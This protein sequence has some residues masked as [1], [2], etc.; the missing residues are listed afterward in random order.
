MEVD[1]PL[2]QST[3]IETALTELVTECP[4]LAQLEALLSQFNVFRV[5][6]ATHSELRHS[7]MLAWLFDPSGSHGL[8]DLF[9]RRWLMEVMKRGAE[10]D[11]RPKGWVSP[12]AIDVME[13]DR[14]ETHREFDFIDL[15]LEI[16]PKQGKP[17]LICIENKVGATEGPDQLKRYY[18]KIERR[19]ESFDRRIYV[20]LTAHEGTAK[21]NQF[22]DAGYKTVI[23]VLA[24]C[25]KQQED[26][27]GPEPLILM[28]H[29]QDLLKEFF[30]DDGEAAR[31]ARRIY[32]KH[33]QALDFIF[34][35]KV[36]PKFEATNAIE[37]ALAQQ[38]D[39]LELVMA[40]S[41]KGNVRFLPK[42][43][44]VDENTGGTAWGENSR[45]VLCELSLWSKT[46]NLH[47]ILG[48][49]PE[50]WAELVWQR[51]EHPPFRR[52]RNKRPQYWVKPH[53]IKSSISVARLFELS[54][55]ET[56]DELM[57]WLKNQLATENFR[58]V[59]AEISKLLPSLKAE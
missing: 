16:H 54:D 10:L 34:E 52:T 21:H 18:E 24:Q 7:N 38:S 32:M 56:V 30:M 35:N 39:R 25:I 48:R 13:I 46:V 29:Y 43:W 40:P 9:L 36:D 2:T 4:E 49:A 28:T 58:A 19:F 42:E 44:A 5:L 3:E 20:Y 57:P 55:E 41:S 51:A 11:S 12:I 1:S 22:I 23:A 27:I 6:G 50:S 26:S 17:W 53:T 14:V 59:T 47:V 31:L 37:K 15:L 33:R 45:Y 8:D